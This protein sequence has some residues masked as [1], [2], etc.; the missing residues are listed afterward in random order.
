MDS[1]AKGLGLSAYR[2]WGEGFEL[3]AYR[4]QIRYRRGRLHLYLDGDGAPWISRTLV[5]PD[6]TSR[7]P[8]ALRL[9][10][11]DPAPAVY[12]ARPCYN[13]TA[14]APGC[15]PWI[16]TFGRYS[17]TV[18]ASMAAAVRT[19]IENEAVE[20][21]VLVGYSGGGVLAWL[22]AQRIPEVRT[23]VTIASNLDV[24]LWSERHGFSRLAGSLNPAAGPPMRPGVKQ[25][26]LVGEADKNVPPDVIAAV[27]DKL[28][29]EAHVLFL[30]SNHRCCWLRFWPDIL[31]Q[32][33]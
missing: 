19:L 27:A 30:E 26:H 20:D 15:N 21:L 4:N 11:L 22:L 33:P 13:G 18:V 9:M 31:R 23:L 32:L 29:T 5:N 25:W 10:A 14:R 3:V 28:G 17:E 1:L 2:L 16:W 6:P 8:L 7:N 12:L 24:D